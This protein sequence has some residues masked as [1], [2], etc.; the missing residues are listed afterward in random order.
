MC[1]KVVILQEA[2]KRKILSRLAKNIAA[3]LT[4]D[5]GEMMDRLLS[6]FVRHW[7][8]HNCPHGELAIYAFMLGAC[9]ACRQ[10]GKQHL[11]EAM[12][13][14]AQKKHPVNSR[15]ASVLAQVAAEDKEA[16]DE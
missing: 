9:G 1:D 14:Y 15:Y 7:E 13:A 5:P 6:G 8:N 3:N 16:G 11:G 4:N 10:L 2:A 12:A